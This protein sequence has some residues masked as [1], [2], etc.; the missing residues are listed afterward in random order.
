MRRQMLLDA[1]ALSL[2]SCVR[3]TIV[4]LTF[5]EP[6]GKPDIDIKSHRSGCS[7]AKQKR[8]KKKRKNKSK[9]R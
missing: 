3:S 1:L 9:Q 4:P 2:S 5:A 7:V 8:A 6:Y